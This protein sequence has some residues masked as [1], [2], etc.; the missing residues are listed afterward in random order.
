[1]FAFKGATATLDASALVRQYA[2]ALSNG[3]EKGMP[4]DDLM[5]QAVIKLRDAVPIYIGQVYGDKNGK[6]E[7]GE[8]AAFE[9]SEAK[10]DGAQGLCLLLWGLKLD[11]FGWCNVFAVP[12]LPI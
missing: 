5:K 10:G 7:P 4:S 1:M 12:K 11:S 9:A 8:Q 3:K 2:L 6:V